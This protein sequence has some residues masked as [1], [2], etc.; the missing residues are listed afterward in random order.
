M[1]LP[2]TLS[3]DQQDTVTCCLAE[4]TATGDSS[5]DT[6]FILE[7]AEFVLRRR[8]VWQNLLEDVRTIGAAT[9]LP[10]LQLTA[11]GQPITLPGTLGLQDFTNGGEMFASLTTYNAVIPE[12]TQEFMMT[13]T[14]SLKHTVSG[15]HIHSTATL[16]VVV[17]DVDAER[18][19][20]PTYERLD[21]TQE[22]VPPPYE[23][24]ANQ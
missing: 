10:G 3:I 14:V 18:T 20:P 9:R 13:V 5:N 1:T 4:T 21:A 19:M 2:V 22:I 15:R 24:A 11:D 23:D 6:T 8:L 7:I 16:P 17:I 12:V